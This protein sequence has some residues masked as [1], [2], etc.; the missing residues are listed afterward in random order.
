MAHLTPNEENASQKFFFF[1][2]F[3]FF[4]FPP[5]SLWQHKS[6]YFVFLSGKILKQKVNSMRQDPVKLTFLQV[7][8]ITRLV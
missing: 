4:F 5:F 3:V 7:F 8:S 6:V 1:L 2:F